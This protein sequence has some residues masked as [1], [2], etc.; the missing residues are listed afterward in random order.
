MMAQEL[1]AGLAANWDAAISAGITSAVQN[2]LQANAVQLTAAITLWIM[3]SGIATMFGR[4]T[5]QEWVYGAIRAACLGILLT[6]AGF[7]QWIQRP[8]MD[9]IPNWIASAGTGTNVG[10]AQFDQLRDTA[11]KYEAAVL[12]QASCIYPSCAMQAM[13]AWFTTG[14]IGFELTL[15]FALWEGARGMMGVLVVTTPFLLFFYLFQTTRHVAL[16]LAGIALALLVLDVMLQTILSFSIS[17]DQAFANQANGGD[18]EQQLDGLLKIALFFV[19]GLGMT[20]ISPFMAAFIARGFLPSPMMVISPAMRG[21][22]AAGR[23]MSG[24]ASAMG[25]AVERMERG[26]RR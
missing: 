4:I 20:V 1:F 17:A 16:N 21:V 14:A 11:V 18:V 2:E 10:P 13:R 7:S 12:Q 24:A 15:A 19:F 22:E 23:T 6:A 3:I 5:M 26:F 25:R 9:D 8:L